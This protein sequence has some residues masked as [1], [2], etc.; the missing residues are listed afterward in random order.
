MGNK[1]DRTVY[2]GGLPHDQC[3]FE[4]M[5]LL[6]GECGKMLDVRVVRDK[7]TAKP[8][9][10]VF[11]EFASKASVT[12]ALGLSG[13]LV[14]ETLEGGRVIKHEIRVDR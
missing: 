4:S 14:E 8:N 6:F 1:D 9:G 7:V 12:L 10:T 13:K 11:V 5:Q 2:V 3:N